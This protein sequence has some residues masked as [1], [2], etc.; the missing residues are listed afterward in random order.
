MTYN[1]VKPYSVNQSIL[2]FWLWFL[3]YE[4]Q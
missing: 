1:D 3:H 2:P 4:L